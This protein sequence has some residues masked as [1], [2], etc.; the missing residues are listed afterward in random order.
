MFE[1]DKQRMLTFTDWPDEDMKSIKAPVLFITGDK[2]VIT[3]EHHIAMSRLVADSQ[4]VVLP[5]IHGVCIGEICVA[6]PGSKQVQVT[7]MLVNEFLNK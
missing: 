3:I 4:L 1:Q 5:G 6:I 7:A 2:D